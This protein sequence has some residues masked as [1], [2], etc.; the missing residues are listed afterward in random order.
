MTKRRPP[1][2]PQSE[3]A[4]VIAEARRLVRERADSPVEMGADIE[5]PPSTRL[6]R[7]ELEELAARLV[8][9]RRQRL[10]AR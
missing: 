4:K 2:K 1:K 8:E 9:R 5:G 10:K 6:T 7:S 3:A